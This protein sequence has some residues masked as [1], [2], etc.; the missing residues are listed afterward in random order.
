MLSISKAFQYWRDI[1]ELK[2]MTDAEVALFQFD[3]LFVMFLIC[4]SG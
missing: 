3:V 2:C 1:Q 4:V